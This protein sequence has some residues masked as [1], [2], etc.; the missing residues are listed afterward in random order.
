MKTA[1]GV[2]DMANN[3]KLTAYERKLKE[4]SKWIIIER[5]LALGTSQASVGGWSLY[6]RQVDISLQCGHLWLPLNAP[7]CFMHM[8]YFF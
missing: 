4:I 7:S 3:Q 6:E 5:I 2:I 8:H 1:D